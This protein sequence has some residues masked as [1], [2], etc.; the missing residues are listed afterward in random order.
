MD[1]QD[2]CVGLIFPQ[3]KAMVSKTF[4][5]LNEGFW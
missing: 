5:C 1:L 2:C 3:A 4:S